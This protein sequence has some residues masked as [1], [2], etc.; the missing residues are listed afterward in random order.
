MQAVTLSSEGADHGLGELKL[1][2]FWSARTHRSRTVHVSNSVGLAFLPR[3]A[4]VISAGCERNAQTLNRDAS[5]LEVFVNDGEAMVTRVVLDVAPEHRVAS[6]TAE[7]GGAV[8][9]TLDA[10]DLMAI[11]PEDGGDAEMRAFEAF[12]KL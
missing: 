7:G 10:W 3:Q 12:A 4:Q 5:V 2:C 11:W 9:V 8:L 1:H 6:L